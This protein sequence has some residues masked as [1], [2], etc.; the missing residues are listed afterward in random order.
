[1]AASYLLA[2]RIDVLS[3]G[4]DYDAAGN[5]AGLQSTK[6]AASLYLDKKVPP[7]SCRDKHYPV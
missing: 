3:V 5:A 1:M 2:F 6:V 4:N 7:S